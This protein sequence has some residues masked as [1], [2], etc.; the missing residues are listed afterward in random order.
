MTATYVLRKNPEGT[1]V[2][3]LNTHSGQVLLTS[4][5]YTDKNVALRMVDTARSIARRQKSYELA[6]AE[7][8]QAYFVLK[9][10]RQQ[11]IGRSEMYPDSQSV[12]QGILQ[13]RAN[14]HG[15]RLEDL[16]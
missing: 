9:N 15:A 10:A 3:T 16:T 2:F 8:G 14:T 5:V 1:F 13:A 6:E 11:V 7:D 12:L 4:Q